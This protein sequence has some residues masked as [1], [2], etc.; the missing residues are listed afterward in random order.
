MRGRHGGRPSRRIILQRGG[1]ASVRTAVH[2]HQN[3]ADDAEV[4]PPGE[5]YCKG[6]SAS[7][8]T[9]VHGQQ[10]HCGR[11]GGRPS[12]NWRASASG[13]ATIRRRC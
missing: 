7:A 6:G 12:R 9:E 4:V 11:R 1:S 3:I 5:S 2:E 8:R 13:D 10:T